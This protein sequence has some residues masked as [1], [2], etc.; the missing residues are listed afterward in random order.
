[1][2]GN[3]YKLCFIEKEDWEENVGGIEGIEGM[4]DDVATGL[5]FR[6]FEEVLILW[7]N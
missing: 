6:I 7:F 4:S 3:C 5:E 2:I 1:M